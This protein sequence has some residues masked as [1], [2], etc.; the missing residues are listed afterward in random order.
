MRPDSAKANVHV[1]GDLFVAQT[2]AYVTENFVLTVC[3]V[4]GCGCVLQME[5]TGAAKVIEEELRRVGFDYDATV[6]DDLKGAAKIFLN[7]V[8][9]GQKTGDRQLDR[10][11]GRG[12]C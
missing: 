3:Q 10:V 8:V 1:I 6:G 5:S 12:G 7:K 11:G 4:G 2:L 9:E